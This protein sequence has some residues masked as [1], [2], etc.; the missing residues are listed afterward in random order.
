[1]LLANTCHLCDV[2]FRML[3]RPCFLGDVSRRML[4]RPCYLSDVQ[5]RM[6]AMLVIRVILPEM[7]ASRLEMTPTRSV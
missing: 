2:P 1:M 5:G 6:L 4:A 3:A 7:P